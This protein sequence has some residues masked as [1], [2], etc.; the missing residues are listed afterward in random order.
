[1]SE[2]KNVLGEPLKCCCKFPMTGFYRTGYCETGPEDLG[3]HTVCVK[4]TEKFLEFTKSV[5]NDLSTPHPELDFPGLIAGDRWCLC[6]ARWLEAY[7]ADAAP[8]VYLERTNQATLEVVDLE[9]LNKH[10]IAEEDV[11]STN[12]KDEK[13]DVQ[14]D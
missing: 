8:D 5:G 10:A 12:E 13:G 11:F 14:S 3:R 6:A 2:Q 4:L 9:M 1:M 7:Q